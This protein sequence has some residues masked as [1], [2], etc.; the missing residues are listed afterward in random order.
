MR[1]NKH[2]IKTNRQLIKVGIDLMRAITR[3]V[4]V[5]HGKEMF[6]IH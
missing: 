4:E 3:F 6:M 2:L 1:V 5:L